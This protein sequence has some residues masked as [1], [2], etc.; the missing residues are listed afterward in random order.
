MALLDG[1]TSTIRL[2]A[3]HAV[4]A[5]APRTPPGL[6][7]AVTP[8]AEVQV[9]GTV[10][11]VTVDPG[12]GTTVRLYEGEVRMACGG[13]TIAMRPGHRVVATAKGLVSLG[14]FDAGERALDA[15]VA[16]G[17]VPLAEEPGLAVTRLEEP[18]AEAGETL[19]GAAPDIAPKAGDDLPD[20]IP[21]PATERIASRSRPAQSLDERVAEQQRLAHH[22]AV[23]E[24]TDDVFESAAPAGADLLFRR[25]RSLGQLGR[26]SEAVEVYKRIAA[27][28]AGRAAEALYLAADALR[29]AGDFAGSAAIADRAIDAGGPNA[30]HA[31][32]VKLGALTG[33]RRYQ[34][35]AEAAETYLASHP[36]GAH[37]G[38]AHF[39][40]GTGLRLER[41][42]GDAAEAYG[43]FLERG[44]GSAAI[45]EDGKFYR[46][47]CLLMSGN[48]DAGIAALEAYLDEHPYGRHAGKA[49]TALGL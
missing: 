30:D 32:S 4:I 1:D 17:D 37:V 41:R 46:G 12:A 39:V 10:F 2:D 36:A 19:A 14:T 7:R 42:W 22:D 15:E 18:V 34:A 23:V 24:L 25:G 47:Y 9:H 48:R 40:R 44:E 28:D 20:R 13:R 35:A 11:S 43:R 21:K 16:P 38:E 27:I 31:W 45:L 26:W 5:V 49:R 33:L 8:D 6:F 29:R 3:G